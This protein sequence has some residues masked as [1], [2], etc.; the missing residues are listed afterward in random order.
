MRKWA[1]PHNRIFALAVLALTMIVSASGMADPEDK[2]NGN[3]AGR[4]ADPG[5]SNE[6]PGHQADGP[7]QGLHRGWDKQAV[8]GQSP[9]T[10]APL[11]SAPGLPSIPT[12]IYDSRR[13]DPPSFMEVLRILGDVESSPSCAVDVRLRGLSIQKMRPASR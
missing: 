7:S 10:P 11:P 13:G 9:T 8:P 6:A 1:G 5:K 4:P 12:P 3:G 2:D